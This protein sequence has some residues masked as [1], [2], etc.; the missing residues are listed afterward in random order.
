MLLRYTCTIHAQTL[1]EHASLN[2][3]QL[4]ISMGVYMNENVLIIK[5]AL[6]IQRFLPHI[7]K[8]DTVVAAAPLPKSFIGLGSAN[9]AYEE[10]TN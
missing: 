1:F 7:P 2:N 10:Q 6:W 3:Y 8:Y 9:C 5:G 4:Q